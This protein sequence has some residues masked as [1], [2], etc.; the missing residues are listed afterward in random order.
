MHSKSKNSV[1]LVSHI[2]TKQ[3]SPMFN[4]RPKFDMPKRK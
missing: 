1:E 3:L 2:S 4:P